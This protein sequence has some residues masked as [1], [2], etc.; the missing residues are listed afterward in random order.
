MPTPYGT[1][2]FL[3]ILIA[4]VAPRLSRAGVLYYGG[5]GSSSLA[6]LNQKDFTSPDDYQYDDFTVPAGQQWSVTS[7]SGTIV[8][9]NATHGPLNTP[10]SMQAYYEIRS[11]VSAGNGGTLLFSSTAPATSV[12][13]A[14]QPFGYQDYNFSALPASPIALGPGTYWLTLVPVDSGSNYAYIRETDGTN[15]VGATVADHSSYFSIAGGPSFNPQAADLSI[16]IS[17]TS[18][19]VPEPAWLSLSVGLVGFVFRRRDPTPI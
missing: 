16:G 5:D 10:L 2:I 18:T 1:S 4:G 8:Y 7:L 3:A 14:L 13:G 6:L 11:G 12:P 15:G 17:G 19:A 9:N